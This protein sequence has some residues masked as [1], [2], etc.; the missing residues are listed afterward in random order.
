MALQ[1]ISSQNAIPALLNRYN[2]LVR[3]LK[4]AYGKDYPNAS[5]LANGD[6]VPQHHSS[7]IIGKSICMERISLS[8]SFSTAAELR[9]QLG[10][11]EAQAARAQAHLLALGHGVILR[12]DGSMIFCSDYIAPGVICPFFT[13]KRDFYRGY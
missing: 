10:L 7:R 12:S 6:V 11:L 5:V 4:A 9:E 13:S 8:P 2:G 1:T 3:S